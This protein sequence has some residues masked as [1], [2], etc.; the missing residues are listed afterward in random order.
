MMACKF[1][2]GVLDRG[3]HVTERWRLEQ[4][5]CELYELRA[6]RDRLVA[7]KPALTELDDVYLLAFAHGYKSKWPK[8][9]DVLSEIIARAQELAK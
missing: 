9:A 4:H 5:N 7:F 2:G 1:C 3:Y 6:L 8:D